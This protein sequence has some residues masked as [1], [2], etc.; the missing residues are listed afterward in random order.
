MEMNEDRAREIL[1]K[2]I[3]E[4]NNL[5][6]GT[7]YLSWNGEVDVCLDGQFTAP[8]LEAISWWMAN[9]KVLDAST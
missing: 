3:R 4:N 9:K 6:D 7:N 5:H 8:E 2:I 1:G